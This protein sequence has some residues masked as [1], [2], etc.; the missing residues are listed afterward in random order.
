MANPRAGGGR[1]DR[2]RRSR[3]KF[4]QFCADHVDTVDYK[5]EELLRNYISEDGKI[6]PKRMSGNCAKHQRTVAT[7]VK[8]ARHVALLPF[9]AD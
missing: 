8:R 4:C 5:N 2:D 6:L 9:V 7:A 1:R 3:R